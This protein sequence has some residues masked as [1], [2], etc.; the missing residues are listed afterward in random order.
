MPKKVNKIYLYEF[1]TYVHFNKYARKIF[2]ENF[3]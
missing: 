3:L 1:T 2:Q